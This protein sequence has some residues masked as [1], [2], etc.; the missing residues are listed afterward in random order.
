M[1]APKKGRPFLYAAKMRPTSVTLD[2]ETKAKALAIGGGKLA[3][4]VRIAV[5]AFNLLQAAET[6][7]QASPAAS[8]ADTAPPQSAPDV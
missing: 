1:S 2:P 4:G 8:P 5:E 6:A 3:K 7:S